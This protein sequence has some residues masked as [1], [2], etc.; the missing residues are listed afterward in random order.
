ELAPVDD[1]FD[2]G[3]DAVAASICVILADPQ[4]RDEHRERIYEDLRA[5]HETLMRLRDTRLVDLIFWGEH[6]ERLV[7]SRR[8]GRLE[9]FPFTRA[10]EATV[11]RCGFD[12]LASMGRL[13]EL[14]AAWA[15]REY[16][17]VFDMLS[18]NVVQVEP[19]GESTHELGT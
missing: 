17:A 2:C 4:L 10:L 5:Q 1:P 18:A 14:T 13:D 8:H 9:I 11:R 7:Q 15:G 16:P 6:V 3:D 19:P 12:L